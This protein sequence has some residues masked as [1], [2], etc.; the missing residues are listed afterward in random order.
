[1]T[2]MSNHSHICIIPRVSPYGGPGSFGAG[3]ISGL[4]DLGI[5][6]SHDLSNPSVTSV[7]VI[8]GSRNLAGLI[9]AH[10]QEK[11]IV[12]RLNGMNWMHRAVRRS[13]QGSLGSIRYYI[14]SEINNLLLASIRK[15]LA[16]HI[17]YQSQ[18]SRDWWNRVYGEVKP[19]SS[20]VHNAVDLK[21]F[22]PDGPAELPIDRFRILMVEG[23]ISG[24]YQLG[25]ENAVN[26]AEQLHSEHHLSKLLAMSPK[27]SKLDYK[28]RRLK[29][30]GPGF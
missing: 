22:S 5:Q 29:Y 3:L 9:R 14:R 2:L 25:L 13:S 20:V 27:K 1:M 28:T 11:R 17:I 16:K 15:W 26:L 23:N 21:L 6:V 18:F 30:H 8:G 19:E 24:G 10:R 4:N 12:Q 7:L